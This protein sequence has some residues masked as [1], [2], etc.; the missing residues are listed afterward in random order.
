L[1][2]VVSFGTYFLFPLQFPTFSCWVVVLHI[3]LVSCSV[4][5][6]SLLCSGEVWRGFCLVSRSSLSRAEQCSV[7]LDLVWFLFVLAVVG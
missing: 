7:G 1:A 2:D 4:G 3:G 6:V 5:L